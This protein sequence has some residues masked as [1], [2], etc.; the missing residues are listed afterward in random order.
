MQA[1]VLSSYCAA[2]PAQRTLCRAGNLRCVHGV[3]L[4]LCFG[5]NAVA[6]TGSFHDLPMSPTPD[7]RRRF[8]VGL[9]LVFGAV[10]IVLM[11]W[12]GHYQNEIASTRIAWDTPPPMWPFQTG[13]VFLLAINAPAIA[14][15]APVLALF[16]QRT[17]GLHAAHYGVLLAS[18][19]LW[20]WW[21][22]TRLDQGNLW[23]GKFR[24]ERFHLLSV[25]GGAAV[26]F[27]FGFRFLVL[28][29][30]WWLT[31]GRG[32]VSEQLLTATRTIAPG[33]WWIVLAVF[34]FI[35]AS[36]QRSLPD[37]GPK[38]RRIGTMAFTIASINLLIASTGVLD[39]GLGWMRLPNF[40]HIHQ[41][42]GTITGVVVDEQGA[43]ISGQE[44]EL[45]PADKSGEARWW[46][47]TFE[48]TN[49]AGSYTFHPVDPG[50]YVLA[51]YYYRAPT[52]KR[53]Y[54]SAF[55]PGVE[56]EAKAEPLV[57]R[58]NLPL[59]AREFH[60][61][62]L[63]TATIQID[64]TWPDGTRPQRSNLE[65]HNMSYPQQAVIGDL[66]PQVD[67][68]RG[69]FTLPLGFDYEAHAIVNCEHE[70]SMRESF[71][72]QHFRA[73]KN[74]SPRQMTFAVVGSPCRLWHPK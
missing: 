59:V 16:G 10:A 54:A 7:G 47:R 29:I 57:V 11:I 62:T 70:A 28:G 8:Q 5:N 56:T 50:T 38:G 21:I 23:R 33:V 69:E 6:R 63:A 52:G 19:L 22:G 15:A 73:D 4:M 48:F 25:L 39:L 58:P 36:R 45:L 71:P 17:H 32:P 44:V 53:P 74:T 24:W 9:P 51:I 64:V 60:L 2:S 31:S 37:F 34:L 13:Y 68:G 14:V 67:Q 18:I 49:A 46:S 30:Y 65:F 55:Y 72:I 41:G 40:R 27:Y 66:A 61:R 12:D 26:L 1:V 20:W 43:R 3:T 35:A 42:A